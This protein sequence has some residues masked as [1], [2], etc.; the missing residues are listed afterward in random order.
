[1][2]SYFG[3]LRDRQHLRKLQKERNELIARQPRWDDTKARVCWLNAA[4]HRATKNGD[5]AEVERL[6]PLV[7]KARE[8]FKTLLAFENSENERVAA[9]QSNPKVTAEA[10][11]RKAGVF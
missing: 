10:G 8:E 5:R 9:A 1:V 4:L 3:R 6:T 2:K 7:F 11:L